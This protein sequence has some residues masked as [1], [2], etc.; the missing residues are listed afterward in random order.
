[1][2]LVIFAEKPV[3][4]LTI[5]HAVGQRTIVVNP[6]KTTVNTFA[7]LAT[8]N[9]YASYFFTVHFKEKVLKFILTHPFFVLVTVGIGHGVDRKLYTVIGG[10]RAK[11]SENHWFS[12]KTT[13]KWKKRSRRSQKTRYN[14]SKRRINVILETNLELKKR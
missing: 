4:A 2:N 3:A 8:V 13:H 14:H 7:K 9:Q 12:R 11:K 6:S 1:V 5:S 10:Q